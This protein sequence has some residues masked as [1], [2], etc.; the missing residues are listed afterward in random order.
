MKASP[1]YLLLFLLI[2]F[3]AFA[4]LDPGTG[5]MLLQGI[6]GAIAIGMATAKLWW[7]KFTSLFS[8]KK[9]DEPE[10]S[11]EAEQDQ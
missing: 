6:I 5:S 10:E 3:N 11:P 8:S 9:S 4:Y 1:R 2:P 7:Y